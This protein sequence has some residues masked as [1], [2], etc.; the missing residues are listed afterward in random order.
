MKNLDQKALYE[1]KREISLWSRNNFRM[2]RDIGE[3]DKKIALLI[4][5]RV[6]LEVILRIV[7]D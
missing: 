5:N 2:E 1:L 6:T 7:S 3:L 4:R